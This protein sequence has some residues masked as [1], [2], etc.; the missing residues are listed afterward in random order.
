M[1]LET[2]KAASL[3]VNSNKKLLCLCDD[4]GVQF[5][6]QYQLLNRVDKHRCFE[7]AKINRY[8]NM[9]RENISLANSKRIGLSHPRWNPHKPA[10]KEYANKIRRLSEKV[11]LKNKSMI[12]PNNY[13]RTVCGVEGGYQLDHKISIKQGFEIGLSVED[14]SALSNL[15]LLPWKINRTKWATPFNASNK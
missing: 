4:C 11:Y 10:F 9:N 14:M 8:K 12:N 15:Q 5:N 3:K 2:V 7:C 13:Q 1:I 6:R